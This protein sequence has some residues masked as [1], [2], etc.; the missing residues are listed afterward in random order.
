MK[1]HV[2]SYLVIVMSLVIICSLNNLEAFASEPEIVTE[3]NNLMANTQFNIGSFTMTLVY[4]GNGSERWIHITPERLPNDITV[5][6]VDY[7][8]GEKWNHTYHITKTEHYYIGPNIKYVYLKGKP[9]GYVV[10]TNSAH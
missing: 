3:S 4:R 7:S 8:G 1:R 6:M 5:I 9:G 10:V 2:K